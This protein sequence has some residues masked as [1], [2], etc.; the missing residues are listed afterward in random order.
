MNELSINQFPTNKNEQS[1]MAARF[2][3]AIA[4]GEVSPLDA[5]AKMKSLQEVITLFLKDE[6]VSNAVITE[7][8]KYGRGETPSANGATFQVKETGVK[9]DFSVCGDIVWNS[10][11]EQAD[12]IN[13]AL[14]DREKYLKTIKQSKTEIDEESGEIYTILPPVKTS[15]TSY[16]VTFKKG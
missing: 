14:K 3:Q 5:V 16:T 4:D 2:A 1:I 15:T 10:L 9:Y 6:A 12:K 8:E 7:V 11:K 13:E